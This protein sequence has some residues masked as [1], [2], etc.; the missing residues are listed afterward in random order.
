VTDRPNELPEG[1]VHL[2]TTPEFDERSVPAGLLAAHRVA[3]GVWGRLRVLSGSLVFRFE[4]GDDE[5]RRLVA[6]DTQ[7][8]PPSDPHHLEMTG[9]VRFLVEFHGQP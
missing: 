2:R 6:G 5:G 9:S 3:A 4:N 7:A 8:I 1:L